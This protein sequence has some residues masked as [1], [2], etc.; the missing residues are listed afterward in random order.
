MQL[1][2]ESLEKFSLAGIPKLYKVRDFTVIIFSE[3]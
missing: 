3:F 2:K 1:R